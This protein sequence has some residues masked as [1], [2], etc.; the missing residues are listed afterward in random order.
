MQL[1]PRGAL[2]N[3]TIYGTK[4]RPIIKM[5]KIGAAL[6]E[7][8]INKVSS[9]TIREALL[10]RLNEYSGDA[11]KAFAGKNAI[12]KNP[13]YLNAEHTKTAPAMVKIVEWEMYYPI[14][15]LITPDLKIEKVIDNGI[16]EILKND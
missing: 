11:K 16:K 1:T 9:P 7:A 8:T 4:M 6:D 2:H 3:E 13:I 10:K 15:K 5:V 14:R 12:T